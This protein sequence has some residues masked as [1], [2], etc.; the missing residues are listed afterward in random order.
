MAE[1]PASNAAQLLKNAAVELKSLHARL[2]AMDQART[3]PIAV[4]GLGCRFPGGADNPDLYWR[5]LRAGKDAI[6][7]VPPDRWNADEY[8]HPDPRAPG[9]MSTRQGGFL[10][11]VD[12]FDPY[13]F[14]ISPRECNAMDP[15]QRLL[16]EVAWEALEDAGQSGPMLRGSSTM[17]CVGAFSYD[18]ALLQQSKPEAID[19]Y[20]VSG[21][22]STIAGRLSYLL[23]LRGPA[24]AVDT[25]CS[26]SLTA[27]HLACQGLRS[28]E[29]RLAV[30]GGVN[31]M[32][33][34][35]GTVALTK[36]QA[37]SPDGRCKTFDAKA[38]G[39]GRGEGCGVV[40]L[41][42]LSDALAD[43]D[44]IRAVIR[45]SAINQD[46]AST[47]F[48]SPNVLAQQA[49]I[50]QALESAGIRPS[51]VGYI[52]AHGTGTTL[53]DPIEI[54]ALKAIYGQPRPDGLPCLVGSVKTNMG[55]L[56]GA[57]GIA[58]LIKV[59]L[60]LE[61]EEIP[62]H[63]HFQKLNPHIS[64]ENTPFAIP[65]Q[66]RAWPAGT[67]S[68]L[69]TV[70]AFGLNGTNAHVILEEAPRPRDGE[71]RWGQADTVHLLP[72]SARSPEAL[73]A[74]A[75]SYRTFLSGP[76][77]ASLD[78]VCFTASV[79]RS[80]HEHR[81]AVV[82]GTAPSLRERLDAFLED[83]AVP[84]S[85]SGVAVTGRRR[86]LVFVFAP[87]GSQW[88]GMGSRL[89][90][91]EPVFRQVIEQCE[92]LMR[93]Q[94]EGSL[95][96]RLSRRDDG[97]WMDRI[98][99]LQPTLFAFQVALAALWRSRGIVPDAVVGHSMGEVAAAHAAGALTLE[100]AVRI[101]CLRSQLFRGVTGEG[102]MGVVE[103]SLEE[104][105]AA[106]KGYEGRVSVAVS[107]SPRST[108]LSGDSEALEELLDTLE[109]QG[110]FCGWGVADVASHSPQMTA[111]G[112]ELRREL[113]G[114]QPKA[115]SIPF[116]SPLTGLPCAGAELGA[117]YWVRNLRQKVLFSEAVQ[118][119]I[120]EGH[121]LFVELSP[122]PILS[123][124]VEDWLRVLEKPGLAL[125]SLRRDEAPRA[126]MLDALAALYSAGHPLDWKQQFPSGGR[127]VSLP[128]YPW[129]RE[130]FWFETGA[131]SGR[132]RAGAARASSQGS[133]GA[134]LLGASWEASVPPGARYWE[135]QIDVQS[136]PYLA[137]HRIQGMIVLPAVA[138]LEMA[139][140]GARQ[141]MGPSAYILEKVKFKKV[142]VLPEGEAVRLQLALLP[143]GAGVARF[144]LS[145][146]AVEASA[147][148]GWTLHAEGQVRVTGPLEETPSKVAFEE[149]VARCPTAIAGADFYREGEAR[150]VELG[151][152]FRGISHV[153]R[154]DTEAFATL[155]VPETLAAELSRYQVHPALLDS[156]F[157]VLGAISFWGANRAAAEATYLPL[158]LESFQLQGVPGA[159]LR[160]HAVMTGGESSANEGFQGDLFLLDGSGKTVVEARGLRFQRFDGP[161]ADPY[162]DWFHAL[163]WVSQARPFRVPP[164]SA[165][166]WLILGD[167]GGVGKAL[168]AGLKAQG[169][170]CILA[171]SG[172]GYQCV[173]PGE[174]E[175]EATSPQDFQ[176]VLRESLGDGLP[177]CRGVVDLWAL[178]A[179]EAV[180]LSSI[181]AAQDVGFLGGM[182]LIQ[183]L[184]QAGFRTSPRL[185]LVTRGA[186]A[187]GAPHPVAV[188]QA[189]R[190][191]LGRTVSHEHPELGCVRIDLDPTR[192]ADDAQ[193]LLEELWQ[194]E[195]EDQIAFR[196]G[197]RLVAR[198]SRGL[199]EGAEAAPEALQIH[200]AATYL[201]TG[202][203]RGLG[204]K[205]AE[206]LVGRGARHLVLTGRRE[207]PPETRAVLDALEKSGVQ[208]RVSHADVTREEQMEALLT[209]IRRTW[210]P[211]KGII[212]SAVTLDD[213]VLLRQTRERFHA[214]VS[215]KLDGAW[216][217]HQLT[218]EDALDFFVLFSS[219]SSLL[220]GPA[221]ASY[222]ASNAFVDALAHHRR[223]AG[224]PGLSIN[225]GPWSE[226][227]LGAAQEN[228]GGRLQFRGLAS[229]TP[230]QGVETF[231]RLLGLPLAQMGVL[232]FNLRQWRE[233]YPKASNS[234]LFE[235]IARQEKAEKTTSR[236]AQDFIASLRAADAKERQKSLESLLREQIAQ[237]LRLEPHRVEA[238]TPLN[239]LGFDSL[240]AV[241]LRNRLEV[242]LG[243][244]LPVTLVW[245]Y[246]TITALTPQLASRVGL[247]LESL[248]EPVREVKEEKKDASVLT[249]VLGEID[250]L[251][252]ESALRALRGD[253]GDNNR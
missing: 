73:K 69:G 74:L 59:V 167:R 205:I 220:G 132:S 94:V 186:Q 103:L 237:V 125:P 8:Y 139:L 55:H 221:D 25:A 180:S 163:K 1:K 107:N 86:G 137:D 110:V 160:S 231:S 148:A 216:L 93:P 211:L 140:E 96:E 84:G 38:D 112:E 92:A 129:Q 253:K 233:Y 44:R 20:G 158:G 218:R 169:E 206:W 53:G 213:G 214:A 141:V 124:D 161:R 65:T 89:L 204:L 156:C 197:K 108:V 135:T 242:L 12:R 142:L 113:K 29:S 48:T 30:V 219:M 11:Q 105:Q 22:G 247:P 7:E 209:E 240:M 126:V 130:R 244:T 66:A 188:S 195:G 192:P 101:S 171:F 82:G 225:W 183:A 71:A 90:E 236:R 9:K 224:L 155:R 190:W 134:A 24:L 97:A 35:V 159:E 80:H 173:N 49:V 235:E 230:Q 128:S 72:L 153:Q 246:P 116:Y 23:D 111:L 178:D 104:A 182:H 207:A 2:E 43:G 222:G 67:R 6:R 127:C 102:A 146:R 50:Q 208:V 3:E 99:Q 56:E 32:L 245:G 202:G 252:D 40:I 17:V 54:E 68:R 165:G 42:R 138:Y 185:W 83:R 79:R 166:S 174:Y 41:K 226:V 133:P 122:H 109:R 115:T 98:D 228:R 26:S 136:F 100:D 4:V 201:I 14:G 131:A 157:Q 249:A 172:K 187:V 78:D 57:A 21:V 75:R 19:V 191:S 217:L 234:P 52:E 87:H 251:S 144:H 203:L 198:L 196:E 177:A 77:A 229:M 39:M 118:R 232:Q 184:I 243:A 212:H 10:E 150:G 248:A 114:L 34:P 227:G 179:P 164:G 121:E 162:G 117:E 193:G 63:L 46:G 175:L 143:E 120:R 170:H 64:L 168:A 149:I 58:G 95:V 91:E 238:E 200:P 51:D 37:L 106:L 123:P 176:R 241:E 36:L 151:P 13:F 81:L 239:S 62:P 88:V 85:V 199:A 210:P 119:L 223:A 33:S 181:H 18:Y 250:Q 189:P 147:D 145:S 60:S 16:L 70:S 15:Q 76:Q 47:S 194:E 215:A 31:L 152:S 28:K 45:G 61:H 154:S 27:I 5:L